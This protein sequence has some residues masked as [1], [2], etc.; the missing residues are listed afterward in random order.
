MRSVT[1]VMRMIYEKSNCYN[2]SMVPFRSNT[3]LEVVLPP[4][5]TL[6]KS[7][8]L[9][10]FTASVMTDWMLLTVAKWC[11]HRWLIILG[12]KR[13]SFGNI[14]RICGCGTTAVFLDVKNS[15]ADNAWWWCVVM[16][17]KPSVGKL[18]AC[19]NA[20]L[21][22]CGQF[23]DSYQMDLLSDPKLKVDQMSS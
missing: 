1:K 11:T 17:W 8:S 4:L 13:K 3:L 15:L 14:W 16:M 9:R 7:S 12:E 5:G 21:K 20:L 2:F 6:L 10:S 23:Y 22:F 19:Q 18:S